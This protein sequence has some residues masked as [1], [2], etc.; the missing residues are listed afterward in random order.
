MKMSFNILKIKFIVALFFISSYYSVISIGTN[1]EGKFPFIL[2]PHICTD[3]YTQLIFAGAASQPLPG[4]GQTMSYT[5]AAYDSKNFRQNKIFLPIVTR[6]ALINEVLQPNPFWNAALNSLTL[7][8]GLTLEPKFYLVAT[9]TGDSKVYIFNNLNIYE[10]KNNNLVSTDGLLDSNGNDGEINTITTA[11]NK[12]L[13]T[14]LPPGAL[15]DNNTTAMIYD[16]GVQEKIIPIPGSTNY[17]T[18]LKLQASNTEYINNT[19]PYFLMNTDTQVT[20]VDTTLKIGGI[21]GLSTFYLG[22]SGSGTSGIKAISLA[23]GNII[24]QNLEPL[25]QDNKIALTGE[26]NRPLYI[27]QITGSTLSTGLSYLIILGGTTVSN[28]KKSIVYGLPIINYIDPDTTDEAAN[29]ILIGQLANVNQN[30][31]NLFNAVSPY[32]FK[33]SIFTLPPTQAQD[34]YSWDNP[35]AVVGGMPLTFYDKSIPLNDMI[36]NT[37]TSSFMINQI[38]TFKD[39]VFASTSYT[40]ADGKAIGGIFYSQALLNE[41]G[42]VNRWTLWMRKDIVGNMATSTYIPSFGC[43]FGILQAVPNAIIADN[44]TKN[45]PFPNNS[46]L[47]NTPAGTTGIQK[48]IDLPYTHPGIGFNT[49]GDTTLSPSYALYVG[50]KV[51]ILQQ[52]AR[53]SGMLPIIQTSVVHGQNGRMPTTTNQSTVVFEGGA[54]KNSGVLWTGDIAFNTTNAWIVVGGSSGVFILSD[55]NGDGTGP[56]LLQDNFTG[57]THSHAWIELGAFKNVRKIVPTEGYLYV[58]EEKALWRLPMTPENIKRGS[59]CQA[60][61]ILSVYDLPNTNNY[62]IFND[63]LI[64]QNSF[65]LASS[66]GLFINQIGTIMN[67]G[68]LS[69]IKF[70]LPESFEAQPISL[71]PVTWNGCQLDWANGKDDAVC[72]NIYV[73]ATSLAK[74]YSMVYRMVTYGNKNNT[75]ESQSIQLLPNYFI[76]NIPTY[77][78]NPEIEIYSIATDGASLFTHTISGSAGLF[79]SIVGLINPFAKHGLITLKHEYNFIDLISQ[80]NTF[81]GYPTYISGLGIWLFVDQNGI[82]GLC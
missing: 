5:I 35:Q 48:I 69:P 63:I 43:H 25:I 34:L 57:L 49:N 70:S 47:T 44:F 8:P 77:Y 59:H 66:C 75:Q 38:E 67:H 72:G 32:T 76:S 13:V 53:N 9:V 1:Q 51:V 17:Y 24:P 45:G 73:V 19:T 60:N 42:A 41:F 30:P 14:V 74:H 18:L 80:S 26:S 64:S 36:T 27:S 33:S 29:P 2:Y 12:F 6:H 79:R 37:T 3:P 10:N 82:Q 15:F 22:F 39:S 55:A 62:S 78:Y 61:K 58:L 81:L 46:Y 28:L 52:T 11:N 23:H 71:Y 4:K 50:N 16:F 40:N 65:I 21:N 20:I 68:S 54:L 7:L 56:L 31:K